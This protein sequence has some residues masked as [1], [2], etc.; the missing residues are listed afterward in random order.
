MSEEDHNTM[1]ATELKS[2]LYQTFKQKGWEDA[3]K[4]QLRKR[5]VAELQHSAMKQGFTPRGEEEQVDARKTSLTLR[6]VNSLVADHLKRCDY[7]YTLSI[8]LPESD[9]SREKMFTIPDLL[10]LLHVQP[11]SPLYNKLAKEIPYYEDKGFLWQLLIELVSVYGRT[12]ADKVVQ[13]DEIPAYQTSIE[14]KLS[15][16]DEHYNILDNERKMRGE[17]LV[18]ERLLLLQKEIEVKSRTE[19]N[20]E[21][22]RY[23]ETELK[24][25]ELDLKEK[26]RKEISDARREMETTFRSRL[27]AV[28]ARERSTSERFRQQQQTLERETYSQRQNLLEQLKELQQRETDLRREAEVNARAAKL[29]EDKRKAIEDNLKFREASVGNIEQ[30]Y[31]RKFQEEVKSFQLDQEVKWKERQHDLERKE[32]LI[33]EEKKRIADETASIQK[34]AEEL[35]DRKKEVSA[36]QEHLQ[37]SKTKLISENHRNQM[38]SEKLRGVVDY[39]IMK[40]DNAVLRRELENTKMRL[41]EAASEEKAEKRRNEELI[42]QLTEKMSRPSPEL[43][44]LRGELERT[45]DQLHQER[46]IGKQ[47]EEH[48]KVKVQE[49]VQRNLDLKHQL[50]EQTRQMQEMVK[51]LG[52]LRAML[53]E[54]QR[55]L[56]NEVYRR[57]DDQGRGSLSQ[58]YLAHASLVSRNPGIPADG[59][60][61]LFYPTEDHPS[62][63]RPVRD[64]DLSEES[65]LSSLDE[66]SMNSMEETRARMKQLEVEAETLNRNYQ[67]FQQRLAEPVSSMVSSPYRHTSPPH[68]RPIRISPIRNQSP[69]SESGLIKVADRQTATEVERDIRNIRLVD[70]NFQRDVEVR[71]HDGQRQEDRSGQDMFSKTNSRRNLFSNNSENYRPTLPT[72]TGNVDNQHSLFTDQNHEEFVTRLPRDEEDETHLNSRQEGQMKRYGG[73]E[74]GDERTRGY[75]ETSGKK[76]A[77]TQRSREDGVDRVMQRDQSPL[78]AKGDGKDREQHEEVDSVHGERM[79]ANEE[80]GEADVIAVVAERQDRDEERMRQEEEEQREWEERRR[81]KEEE[82]RLKEEEARERERQMLLQLQRQEG[83]NQTAVAVENGDQG[84]TEAEKDEVVESSREEDGLKIDP[85][86][87]KYMEMAQKRRTEGNKKDEEKVEREES[88]LSQG[89]ISQGSISGDEKEDTAVTK[90]ESKSEDPFEDW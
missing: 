33:R 32:R 55:A 15:K 87:Q 31:E 80:K 59:N 61:S 58:S 42:K 11:S 23:K 47:K 83:S 73:L 26:S 28:E 89:Q 64:L 50:E 9:T 8:F 35:Q 75:K 29:E 38:L 7:E 79:D 60:D 44:S 68:S 16:V 69:R 37:E 62:N 12:S 30:N 5:L 40:E 36:L 56:H 19:M 63:H 57:S 66:G 34:I 54:T 82:R 90:D 65:S 14:R 85:V 18:Q 70:E 51:E 4:V 43:I 77:R 1:S 45:R 67:E 17:H 72:R 22:S 88:E 25:I 76:D 74:E 49:E 2:K 84:K 10:E 86:M 27:E 53:R 46:A 71:G 39:P 24:R 48:W 3:L 78:A 81:K 13:V 6:A 20:L 52:S 41:A 21:L